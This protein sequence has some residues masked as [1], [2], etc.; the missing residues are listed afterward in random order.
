MHASPTDRHRTTTYA[1]L[2]RRLQRAPG[3]AEAYRA[4]RHAACPRACTAAPKQAPSD[5][6]PTVL[7]FRPR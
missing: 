3:I 7:P 5:G 4:G 2:T 6:A 1:A